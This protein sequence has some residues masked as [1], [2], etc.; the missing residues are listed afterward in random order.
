MNVFVLT[1][2]RT[3]SLSFER[4]CAHMTNYTA[5]HES[6]CHMIGDERLNFP[7]NH[8]EID[9]RLAWFL[10]DL[11]KKYGNNA[12]YIHLKRD[13]A[14]VAKSYARRWNRETSIVR[15]YAYG[16]LK[17]QEHHIKN[18]EELCLDFVQKT[19]ANIEAF[20][21]DKTQAMTFD[22]ENLD[23]DFEKFWK[24]V[25]AKGDFDKALEAFKS[26]HNASGSDKKDYTLWAKTIRVIKKL[27][28]FIRNA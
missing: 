10:G 26:G 9:N 5:A 21:A 14:Q 12:I 7:D 1:T 17:L 3:G 15:A 25:N 8:I 18:P 4:A 16:I 24:L 23:V 22:L 20:L 11:E 28:A 6:R 2:G 19:N 13:E 27:P